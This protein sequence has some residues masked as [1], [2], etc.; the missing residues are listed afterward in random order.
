MAEDKKGFLLYAD[1]EELFDEL[2]D[3]TAGKL[4]KHILK[5]VNDKDPISNDPFVKV[6]FIPIK[7]QLKRD[8]EKYEEK[9]EQWSVAGK[10]SAEARR[11]KREQTLN[12]VP[13][14]STNVKTVPT[15]ST[16]NVND[17]VNVTVNDNVNV[18]VIKETNTE[19]TKRFIPPSYNEV[20]IYCFERANGIDAQHFI[21]HYTSNGWMV[22]KNKMKDWKSAV[23]NWERTKKQFNINKNGNT[24][25]DGTALLAWVKGE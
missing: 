14:D 3:E 7:K 10:K 15:D 5:Y 19:K 9:R 22:G 2:S 23:R 25:D 11:L 12:D 20:D 13:T 16:V 8:L 18:S 1:Y 17:N 21:D 6:A 4:I 24:K